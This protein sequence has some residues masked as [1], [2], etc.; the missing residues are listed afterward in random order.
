M[1]TYRR[2]SCKMRDYKTEYRGEKR[3]VHEKDVNRCPRM[4]EVNRN[5]PII[6]IQT[7]MTVVMVVVLAR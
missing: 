3:M 2:L 6:L 7:T 1:S 4:T 5:E